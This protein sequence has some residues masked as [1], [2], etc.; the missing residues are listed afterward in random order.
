MKSYTL[1]GLEM[2][3][4]LV[5]EVIQLLI[6]WIYTELLSLDQAVLIMKDPLEGNMPSNYMSITCL[7]TT[8][9]CVPGIFA[10]K[11]STQM[12]QYVS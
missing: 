4:R 7:C 10:A 6:D 1:L 5:A 11:M 12:A 9:K 8:W 2:I 3:E